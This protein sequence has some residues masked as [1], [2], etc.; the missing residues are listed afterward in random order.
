MDAIRHEVD[1]LLMSQQ[2]GLHAAIG[3]AARLTEY[4]T[5]VFLGAI[6]LD[7][8]FLVWTFGRVKREMAGRLQA[9]AETRRQKDLLAVTLSSI[10][11]AVIVADTQARITFMNG[12]AEQLTGWSVRDAQVR[13]AAPSS[14]FSTRTR[15]SR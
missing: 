8:G 11:D 7:L 15:A 13:C 3:D 12:V 14:T 10:G 6:L 9:A 2:I 4:R 5:V 1:D